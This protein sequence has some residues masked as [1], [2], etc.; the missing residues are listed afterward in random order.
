MAQKLYS[1]N[2]PQWSSIK[3]ERNIERGPLFLSI[4]VYDLDEEV[5]EY[6]TRFAKTDIEGAKISM[7]LTAV[8][9]NLDNLKMCGL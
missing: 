1:E 6:L 4:F 8:F 9:H 3:S 7:I 5:E 2:A